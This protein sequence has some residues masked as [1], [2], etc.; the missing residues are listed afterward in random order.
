MVLLFILLNLLFGYETIVNGINNHVRQRRS[1]IPCGISFTPCSRVV[2][3]FGLTSNTSSDREI[4]A[5]RILSMARNQTNIARLINGQNISAIITDAKNEIDIS[6]PTSQQ[7][8]YE[9]SMIEVDNAILSSICHMNSITKCPL[10]KYR[11]Y[12]GHCNNVNHPLWGVSSKSMQRLLKPTYADKI[13]KPRISINGSSLPSARKISHNLITEP[14]ERY[15]SYSMMIAQWAMFIYEDIIHIGVTTLYEGNQS[16][17]L[18]CCNQQY[19]HPECYPIEADENDMIYSTLTRCLPYVRTA[20]SPRENCSFGPREQVNQATSY[21]DA[22]NIYGNTVERAN[23]LR[24]Y[25]NGSL[26]LLS[27]KDSQYNITLLPNTTDDICSKNRNSRRCFLTDGKFTNLFPTQT[28]LHTIWLRQH[29]NIAKELKDIN[30]GWDDEKLFQESRRIIIAQIQHITYNEFL[31]IIVGMSKLRQYDI[32]LRSNGYDSDYDLRID[33]TALNEYASAVGLFYYSL[34]SDHVLLYES[35][36]VNHGIEK[37]WN[38][39]INDPELFYN[40]KMDTILRFLLRETIQKPGLHMNKYF[41]NEFLRGEGN[42]GLDLAAMIIQMGRDHGIP[43]YTAFRSACG[44]ERPTNFT[45]LADIVVK[46]LDLDELAKLYDHIDDVDLFV[47][48]MAEKPE[49]GA[50]VGPTFACIIGRQFQKIRR[51]DRF[52]YENFFVPTA[53]TLEQLEEIRK[54]T[55]ARIICDNSKGIQQIQPNVFILA[56]IYRNSPVYCNSTIIDTI[57]LTKWTDQEPRLKLP[58]TMATLEKAIRLGAEHAKYL[59]EAEANRIK[60]L[61]GNGNMSSQQSSAI[62]EH[63]ILMAPKMYRWKFHVVQND[64]LSEEERLP[65]ELDL[66]TLQRLLPEIDVSQFV[67]NITNFLGEENPSIEECLSQPLPCDHTTKYRTFSGWCNNLKFPHYGNAFAPMRRLLDPVYEDGF[68]SPRI[69]GDNRRNLPSARKVS[70]AVHAEKPVFHTIYTHMLMQMGQIID[71]DFAHS[72]VSRGPGNTILDCS[73]CD[74]AETVSIHCF[75]IPIEN[76][77]PYFP[78]L[79]DNGEPRCISFVRSLLGQLTLGYRNQLN[80]LTSYIDASFI[81][82]STKC[83]ANKLRL[84]SQGRLAYTNLGFN[85]EA[86]PQGHQERDCRS[87]PQYPCFNAGDERSNE[88]PG[89]TVLHTLFLR[90]HNR[91]AISLSNINSHWFDEKIYLETRRIMGAKVQHIVYNEWLPIILGSEAIAKYDLIPRKIGYYHG[92]DDKCDA[93]MTHEMA[94]AA[95]RFGHSLIRNIFPRM[96]AK[97]QEK[98]DGLDLKTSFNNVTFYYTLE[99]GHIESII[100]G[101]LGSRSM[102]FDRHISDAIRNHLFQRSTDSYTGMDLPAINIQRGRD[103]GIPPYNSY[104]EICGMHRARNFDDLKD[105]MD[106]RTIVELRSVYNH[107]DDIDLFPGIMSEKPLKGALVGPMLICIIGEQFQRLKRCDRFYYENDNPITKFTPDQLAEIRK[108]TLSKLICANSQYA[109][110][111]QP[112]AF[113]MPNNLTNAPVKCSELP[114]ID[115]YKWLDQHFCTVDNRV[116]QMGRT[117]RIKPCIMCTCTAEGVECHAMIIDHCESLLNHYLL[118]EVIDDTA[119]VIQCSSLIRQRNGKL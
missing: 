38:S 103:H 63:S 24:Q 94:T 57:D 110:N 14:T 36:E 72:P 34:F 69:L 106:E 48:G 74:S 42:Y 65:L 13:S 70:N 10:T 2:F 73:R 76:D 35:N 99:N 43:G 93:T 79:N 119:C 39:F 111:I 40:G 113:L 81:Y 52:W 56:D 7:I 75:P 109:R 6:L 29:N 114:E 87:N 71:H 27:Q 4:E 9:L 1:S 15:A 97:Y 68:D 100:M 20:T 17:P 51:G 45:D 84:F 31:P 77:D 30:I 33:G 21:L 37:S 50:L 12:A 118:S 5:Q 26:F 19:I 117:E 104:R 60:T 95:F 107:V 83:E 98:V 112:N 90:E 49:I 115:I 86:L 116:I 61:R 41:K 22:S 66:P 47:L 3:P 91:I 59:N 11:T 96:N 85:R 25:E 8:P 62:C 32:K 102:D 92:Y 23:K 53:F 44:L 105:M 46:S 64:G 16:K 108:T 80:Q 78:H 54:T 88:Q 58:I 101:L 67:G 82:G 89:L 55:L 18:L 28:A